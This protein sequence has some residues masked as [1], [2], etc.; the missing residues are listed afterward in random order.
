MEHPDLQRHDV[1]ADAFVTGARAWRLAQEDPAFADRC[2]YSERLRGWA[3][4]RLNLVRDVAAVNG[5]AS[6]S[7]DGW[8]LGLAP[9]ESLSAADRGTLD[10]ASELCGDDSELTAPRSLYAAA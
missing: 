10:R 5:F 1:P 4:L 3:A 2:A 8:G 7:G 6:V 9:E